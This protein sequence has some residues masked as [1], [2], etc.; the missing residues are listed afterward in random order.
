MPMPESEEA[1]SVPR[2]AKDDQT[3]ARLVAVARA[4]FLGSGFA[5]ATVASIAAKAGIS[6][7][8]VYQY[9]ASKE[10]LMYEVVADA[11]QTLFSAIFT[12]ASSDLVRSEVAHCL[13]EFCL[14]STSEDGVTA[15]R[16]A[17]GEARQFPKMAQ[18]YKDALE[19]Y[20][21]EPLAAWVRRQNDLGR[22]RA[23][24]PKLAADM[25]ACMVVSPFVRD[26][27]LGVRPKPTR[28]EIE[29]TVSTALN[30]FHAGV[31]AR[32]D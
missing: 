31:A 25:L 16:L 24:D 5:G 13:I 15:H 3:Y 23:D 9:A 30:L 7:K 32:L 29:R 6:K 4:E 17:I 19:A 26:L 10:A 8:T 20:V 28:D 21:I 18:A 27:S 1:V 14:L 22:L 2:V 11:C 12:S